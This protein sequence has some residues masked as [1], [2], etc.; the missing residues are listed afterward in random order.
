[1]SEGS[2][3]L[4]NSNNP[5][6]SS[7]SATKCD[8]FK[9]CS[10][11]KLHNTVYRD[12]NAADSNNAANSSANSSNSS[13]TPIVLIHGFPVDHR[14]WDA[15]ADSLNA[16]ID[17]A[18]SEGALKHDVPIFAPDMVGAGL[19]EVPKAEGEFSEA[20]YAHALDALCASYIKLINDLGY[21]RAVW[22]GLS[23]GGYVALD[24]QRLLPKAVAGI[25]LCDTRACVDAPQARAKRLEI[26]SV[27]ERD[28][29]V[30]PVMHFAHATEKDST[31]K[32]SPEFIQTFENWIHDQKPEG[33]AWRQRMA[34]CRPDM[35][36]QLPL[37]T[38][39][40]AIISGTLD[41]SSA[42]EIMRPMADAMTSSKHV[43][44]TVIEDCGHFSAT[45]H[46]YEV[47]SSLV[48]LLLQVQRN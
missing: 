5:N 48:D 15:C 23:M 43:D 45:E 41:P 18:I 20:D 32:K 27:C 8:S 46:P 25:A 19:S 34:A 10:L 47:A 42:P 21:E 9:D 44:F 39:P 3:N 36:D 29:T 7:N 4:N 13:V 33:L 37:I 17:A 11:F 28:H 6:N 35:E 12:V 2:I 1:M 22:V 31:I 14:M 24:V 26:A 16:Q 38:A 40:A 30:E